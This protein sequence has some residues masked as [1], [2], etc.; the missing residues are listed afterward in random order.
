M[1]REIDEGRA[2]DVEGE[3]VVPVA[4][5]VHDRAGRGRVRPSHER[6]VDAG[7]DELLRE[8]LPVR[9][10]GDDAEE[11]DR[12]VEPAEGDRGVERASAG[13]WA[14]QSVVLDEID[15]RLAADDDHEGAGLVGGISP[16]PRA[17][18]VTGMT[19]WTAGA[20]SPSRRR[21]S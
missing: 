11:T 17:I 19:R 3:L 16:D 1:R 20:V 12:D 21:K 15:E 7:L 13:H 10:A 18:N 14:Q 2:A 4:V 5:M 9:V 8:H 6:R